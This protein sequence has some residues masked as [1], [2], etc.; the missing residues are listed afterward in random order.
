[1]VKN[2][3]TPQGGY[4]IFSAYVGSDP[5]STVH[6][7]KI[8]E[9][10]STSKKYLKFLQPQKYPDSVYLPQ[11]KTLKYIEITPKT[12]PILGWPPKKIPTNVHTQKNIH[13][14]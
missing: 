14:S 10:W 2:G 7:K 1:M 11:E 13:F 9:I 6:P 8:S 4:S 12:S 3:H 5:A